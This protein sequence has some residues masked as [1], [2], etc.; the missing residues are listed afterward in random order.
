M[1]MMLQQSFQHGLPRISLGL[2]LPSVLVCL[3]SLTLSCSHL[4]HSRAIFCLPPEGLSQLFPH[5]HRGLSPAHNPLRLGRFG[6]TPSVQCS[7]KPNSSFSLRFR[8]SSTPFLGP[9]LSAFLSFAL[10]LNTVIKIKGNL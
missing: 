1:L 4:F 3:L 5:T 6:A 8:R 9:N 10:L 2:W 7:R